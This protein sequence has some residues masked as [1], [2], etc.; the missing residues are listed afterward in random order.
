MPQIYIFLRK[1]QVG[2]GE[3]FIPN[4]SLDSSQE[5]TRLK[6]KQ[7]Y[8]CVEKTIP[9]KHCELHNENRGQGHASCN[10]NGHTDSE[11]G[12]TDRNE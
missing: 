8:G 5:Q 11:D 1:R 3:D 9:V 4:R 7:A 6:K 12:N 10:H 2:E